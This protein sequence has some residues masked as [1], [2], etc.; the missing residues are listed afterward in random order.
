ML[1]RQVERL[2]LIQRVR[3]LREA[4]DLLGQAIRRPAR[5]RAHQVRRRARVDVLLEQ[6]V[7]R[8]NVHLRADRRQELRRKPALASNRRPRPL[9]QVVQ[10][11]RVALSAQHHAD[12]AQARG[13]EALARRQRL[14]R[15]RQVRAQLAHRALVARVALEVR[16]VARRRA[17]IRQAVDVVHMDEAG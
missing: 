2:A 11:I 4:R 1:A 17:L 6:A 10:L 9:H 7:N 16:A 5:R 15:V 13:G 3:V 12:H 14:L 8:R